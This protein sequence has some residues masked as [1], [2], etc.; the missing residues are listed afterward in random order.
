MKAFK[1]GKKYKPYQAD[2]M[3]IKVIRRTAKT[4]FCEDADKV[5]FSMRVKTDAAGNEYAVDNSVPKAW[6]DAYTYEA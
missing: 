2:L 4:I 5:T 3:P 1:V 6:R